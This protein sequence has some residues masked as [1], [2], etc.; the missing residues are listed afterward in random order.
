VDTGKPE[1]LALLDPNNPPPL[2]PGGWSP[3][4]LFSEG[5]G[6]YLLLADGGGS[7]VESRAA[8]AEWVQGS[9]GPWSYT[10]LTR[11]TG[12]VAYPFFESGVT[13]WDPESDSVVILGEDSVGQG[14]GGQQNVWTWSK[15]AGWR[16]SGV[17]VPGDVANPSWSLSFFDKAS[18]QL[19]FLQQPELNGS[20]EEMY[21]W[22]GTSFRALSLQGPHSWSLPD[23]T[24]AFDTDDGDAA[25]F[26]A[27][28]TGSNQGQ[29]MV[30]WD[31]HALATLPATL[32]EQMDSVYYD[33]DLGVIIAVGDDG[34]AYALEGP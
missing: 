29:D 26:A 3:G 11:T 24:V 19:M 34:S 25:I 13:G 2:S 33:P 28:Q 4:E 12:R 1:P 21:A 18:K 6:D 22:N 9:W 15:H 31:G 8:V 14:G 32:P 17:D 20:P 23:A 10:P 5:N 30:I 7:P 16:D 27:H